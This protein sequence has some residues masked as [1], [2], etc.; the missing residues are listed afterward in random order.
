MSAVALCPVP[1]GA[2]GSTPTTL[3]APLSFVSACESTALQAT[4]RCETVS[5][6]TESKGKLRANLA[7]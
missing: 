7:L 2:S 1:F 3:P 4:E 6:V 5:V